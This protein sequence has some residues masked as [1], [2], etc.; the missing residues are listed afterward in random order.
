MNTKPLIDQLSLEQLKKLYVAANDDCKGF[1]SDKPDWEV[2]MNVLWLAFHRLSSA[3]DPDVPG[4]SN[5]PRREQA[6]LDNPAPHDRYIM[7][8]LSIET[9]T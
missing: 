5:E 3:G 2:L 4:V 1:V 8:I 7:E 6:Y 9:F